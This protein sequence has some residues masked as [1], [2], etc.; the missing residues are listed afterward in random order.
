MKVRQQ[1][2][3]IFEN[4]R[5]SFL[6][7]E[8]LASR[9]GCSR[10]AVWKAVNALRAQGYRISASTNKGYV[11]EP[12]NDVISAAAI[13]RYLGN[14]ADRFDIRAFASV[15]STNIVIR[16]LASKG[17]PEWTAAIA[18]MQTA[19][20]GRLGRSFF[21]PSDTGL[22]LS[23]LLKPDMPADEAVRITTA[24]AVAVAQTIEEVSGRETAIKWVN[25]V[26]IE[27]RKVCGILT[28]ASFSPETGGLEY[29]VVGIGV[30]AY[31]PEGVFREA[32]RDIAVAV[33]TERQEDMRNR[34]AGG[35]L[36]RLY[37]ACQDLSSTITLAEYRRRLM[38]IGERAVTQGALQLE[39]EITGV[40]ENYALKLRLDDGTEKAVRSGE[41]SIRRK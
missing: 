11:L 38:W 6:S 13:K 35:I 18:G 14:L 26:Y 20:R 31:E 22:Y 15:D 16:D 8:E 36:K 39:G 30:N 1:L 28:E 10:A 9:L 24:A 34:L 3:T 32:I 29:A 4:N 7:G 41:I 5:G 27:G 19:G 33:L 17:A 23:I 21:S 2:I 12:E 25:D 40:D 37:L